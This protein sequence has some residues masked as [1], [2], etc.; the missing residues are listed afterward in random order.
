MFITTK[1]TKLMAGALAAAMLFSL[2]VSQAFGA[3]G[4]PAG[5]S[6][7]AYRLEATPTKNVEYYKSGVPLPAAVDWV[8]TKTDLT[9]LPGEVTGDVTSAIKDADGVYWIGTTSGL[10]RV[11]FKEKDARDIV[12]Y[13]AGPKYLYGGDDVVTGLAGDGNGGV[14]VRTASGVYAY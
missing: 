13:M 1:R 4:K 5:A 9:F 14:W 7:Q 8:T 10:Q 6:Y 3:A 2:P 11:N 12:Q